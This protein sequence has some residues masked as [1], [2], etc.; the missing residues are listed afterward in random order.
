MRSK[1]IHLIPLCIICLCLTGS[2]VASSALAADAAETGLPSLPDI[3][4]ADSNTLVPQGATWKYLDDGSD[5]GTSWTS[6]DFDDS[7][8]ASGPA[9]L[10][11]GDG[12]E[13]TVVGYGPDPENKHITT[14]FRH[15]FTATA[16]SALRLRL[17][18]DDGAVVY[19]NG[20]EV[21]RTNMPGATIG[22]QTLASD[23]VFDEEDTF[24]E[25]TVSADHVLRGT[26]VVAVEVHQCRPASSDLSFDLELSRAGPLS[27]CLPRF[28]SPEFLA[29]VPSQGHPGWILV[30]DWTQDGHPDILAIPNVEGGGT[31]VAA[32]VLVNDGQGGFVEATTSVFLGTVPTFDVPREAVVAD[33]NGDS[34]LD[35]FVADHGLDDWPWPGHQNT[36]IL[37][38]PGGKLT[39]ATGIIPQQSDFTH[40]ADAADID[41]DG[42]QDLFI[43]NMDRPPRLWLNDGS[44]GF[45]RGELERL[46]PAQRDLTQTAYSASLFADVD[47][48]GAPDLILG[49]GFCCGF[50][51]KSV[52]LLN[53]GQGW[54][55]LLPD[56]IPA[57]QMGPTSIDHALDIQAADL[58]SDQHLDL[59]F[60]LTE[61]RDPPPQYVGRYI[62]IMIGNG[63]GTFR[64]ETA[65]RLPQVVNHDPDFTF[66]SL[67]DLDH[68]G[69]LDLATSLRMFWN[70]VPFYIN[71]GRG[72]FTPWQQP[73]ALTPFDFGDIDGDGL[74]DL[75]FAVDRWE[76]VP[77]QYFAMRGVGC[78]AAFLPVVLKPGK[79]PEPAVPGWVRVTP[80]WGYI[81][82]QWPAHETLRVDVR[83]PSGS[84]KDAALGT[85]TAWG[86][87]DVLFHHPFGLIA[88]G[89]RITLRPIEGIAVTFEVK[90]PRA[91]ADAT[92]NTIVGV[93]EPGVRVEALVM[94]L[95]GGDHRLEARAAG[96]GTFSFD[97]TPFLDWEAGDQL[98]VWQWVTEYAAIEITEE[99]PEMTVLPG[100]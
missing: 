3:G 50:R 62:Q 80:I 9:Q 56:A 87:L 95:G 79:W 13:A 33:L 77:D 37:S 24:H 74:R 34:H 5:Q 10:G 59:V 89:D 67:M 29:Q 63:D 31:D 16:P 60:V 38:A 27:P 52:V 98:R 15:T 65:T 66:I 76:E 35:L 41:G 47:A 91:T 94:R 83:S 96:D 46:P 18:R 44:G 92:A 88:E 75:L 71:D 11:Y 78:P 81:W 12:D 97:F 69:D 84:L 68:D 8:W 58:N 14:Y 23:C 64:D 32:V 48:D 22:H 1:N 20:T 21:F 17:L 7:A 30:E 90:L 100:P 4:L 39:D 82:G 28:H 6:L 85:A 93:A 43:G 26:N 2:T 54:F 40:S 51:T 72:Y 73:L 61:F 53:D 36:L 57:H 49:T 70:P 55:S 19:V 42:D 45:T 99:S 86:E 25:I